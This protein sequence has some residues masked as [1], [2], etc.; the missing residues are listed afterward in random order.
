[1]KRDRKKKK[2]K[3]AGGRRKPRPAIWDYKKE[4][5]ELFCNLGA[6]PGQKEKIYP[7]NLTAL[8]A[9]LVPGNPTVT[10]PED[11]VANCFPGL[12]MDIRNLDRRFFPGMVF[13][14]VK[15][16]ARLAYLDALSD[17]DLQ[18]NNPHTKQ[19]YKAYKIDEKTAKTL[20][21]DITDGTLDEGTW[22]LDWVE[23][24]K[25]NK[26][27][28]LFMKVPPDQGE[29]PEGW[30]NTQ[31]IVW[32]LVRSLEPGPLKIGLKRR[33]KRG[34][35]KL[36]GWRRRYTDLFTG[37]ISGAFQPGE[38]MQGLC[39]PWQHDFRDC[40]CFY[41]AA[42]HPDAVL[43][44]LYPGEE[45]LSDHSAGQAAPPSSEM[46][47]RSVPLDWI[48]SNR[49]RTMDAEAQGTIAE[50]RPYQM[51]AYEIN[52]RWQDLS[53]VVEGREIG[54]LYAPQAN[55]AANPFSSQN[56][57][58]D[59]LH[60][61]LA[62]LELALT[63]EYLY[64]LFS[65]KDSKELKGNELKGAVQLARDR[66]LLITMNEMWH[67]RWVNEIIWN[68]PKDRFEVPFKPVL[69]IPDTLQIPASPFTPQSKLNDLPDPQMKAKQQVEEFIR[70]ERQI[71]AAADE[72][73]N[74][75]AR[76]QAQGQR[77][78]AATRAPQLRPLTHDVI[79]DF[80]AVEH[81][82]GLVD[83]AYARVIATFNQN[84]N[85]PRLPRHLVELPMRIADDGVQHEIRFLEL[86]Q[87][88]LPFK[89]KDYLRV[90]LAENAAKAEAALPLLIA[91]KTGLLQAY[92][93]AGNKAPEVSGRFIKDARDAMT[94]LFVVGERLATQ[95][96]G[97]PFFEY[98]KSIK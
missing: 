41:W 82:S 35:M 20:F 60:N 47:L 11:A 85:L 62:P 32:R 19:F 53:V 77:P 18:F 22:Y 34:T 75:N 88:L 79:D 76:R 31:S 54:N 4:E 91:I 55:I 87:A 64:A 49:A 40:Q 44:E 36:S 37:V 9:F 28:K 98:W 71:D 57:L 78:Q 17:P 25:N 29:G 39:S 97:I 66:L 70:T 21:D 68:L 73:L 63:F 96:V 27:H 14:F 33:D 58:I 72:I 80:V 92:H 89:E 2:M 86:K 61:Y 10:R 26:K 81:P 83:G 52:R 45:T 5:I 51:D 8:A 84:K 15:D 67:L 50:N 24:S 74:P 6:L 42:N 93:F 30:G 12:E 59:K 3:A 38:L 65:L 1:M 56:E 69:E 16:G 94:K 7:R 23:Q 90:D 13:E 46:I 48:R 43:G 95:K